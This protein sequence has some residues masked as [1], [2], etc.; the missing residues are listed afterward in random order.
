MPNREQVAHSQ[1]HGG[2]LY[3]LCPS[4]FSPRVYTLP[5][6][7]APTPTRRRFSPRSTRDHPPY[8]VTDSHEPTWTRKGYERWQPPPLHIPAGKNLHKNRRRSQ[9][10]QWTRARDLNS[11]DTK[12]DNPSFRFDCRIYSQRRNN[13]ERKDIRTSL[14]CIRNIDLYYH[15]SGSIAIY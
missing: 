5:H 1:G 9:H 2:L 10:R 7:R 8:L 12:R 15:T 4:R 3:P 13:G 14:S 6:P 11:P